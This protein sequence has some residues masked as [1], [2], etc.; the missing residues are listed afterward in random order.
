MSF[1]AEI[2]AEL[3]HIWQRLDADGHPAAQDLKIIADQVKAEVETDAKTVAEA[4]KP[5]VKVAVA[6]GEQVA[7]AAVTT[8]AEDVIKAV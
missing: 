1:L 7:E 8:I 5:V 3:H 6:D 2:E 4:A